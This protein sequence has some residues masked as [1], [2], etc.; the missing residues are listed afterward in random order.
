MK[1]LSK[2][3]GR[4]WK[5]EHH[6]KLKWW[7]FS[8]IN[9]LQQVN[10]I[11]KIT[12]SLYDKQKM[13]QLTVLFFAFGFCTLL[14]PFNK[15]TF[16][17]HFT[18]SSPTAINITLTKSVMPVCRTT[19]HVRQFHL[20][21]HTLWRLIELRFY[22]PLD[23]KQVISETFPQPISLLGMEKLNLTQQKHTFTIKTNTSQ[24]KIK[25]T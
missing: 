13:L 16:P 2:C 24:Q 5:D 12:T 19:S 25:K 21:L 8:Q 23:T 9:E 6:S 22:I 14:L 10:S 7:R 1:T 11:K 20:T 15:I 3:I 4:I 18:K 17:V